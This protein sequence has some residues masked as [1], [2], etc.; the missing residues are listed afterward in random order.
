LC[1]LFAS[2]EMGRSKAVLE[3]ERARGALLLQ[4]REW[5]DAA[6][7]RARA[8]AGLVEVETEMETERLHGLRAAPRN[9]E[10][11]QHVNDYCVKKL[12]IDYTLTKQTGR[13]RVGPAHAASRW[14]ERRQENAGGL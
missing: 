7:P 2:Q 13:G 8:D 1:C 5:S 4:V 6:R 11:Q 9:D 10:Q 14:R 3:G 12:A